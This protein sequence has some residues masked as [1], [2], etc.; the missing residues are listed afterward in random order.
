MAEVGGDGGAGLSVWTP[1]FQAVSQH[2]DLIVPEHPGFGESENPAWLNSVTDLALFYLDL[3]DEM[4]LK[5]VHLVGNSFGG[6]IAAEM[7]S[8]DCARLASVTL[9]G[10]A[11]L[12][13]VGEQEDLF[14]WSYPESTRKL[15][16]NQAI[17][18]RMLSQPPGDAQRAINAKNKATVAKLGQATRLHNPD[19]PK[20]LHRIHTR[21]LVV[22]GA[23]D[24]IHAPSFGQAWVDALPNARL[25][26]IADAGHLP[27]AVPGRRDLVA[28]ELR[29]ALGEHAALDLVGHAQFAFQA[30]A[31]H[32]QAVQAGIFGAPTYVVDGEMFWGQDRLD[33]VE[34]KLSGA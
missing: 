1:F 32:L 20:W 14:R 34:R 24:N 9:I 26:V 29:Q 27:H 30:G 5:D 31:L 4:N 11:G 7:A 12:A 23:H 2:F 33:F 28:G 6:W 10:P 8:R 17:A 13:P 18:D 16:H 3:L 22:W 25:S 19:L 15:F 21:T